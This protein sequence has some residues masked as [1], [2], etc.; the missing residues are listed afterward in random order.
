M[1]LTGKIQRRVYLILSRAVYFLAY[2]VLLAFALS[3]SEKWRNRLGW[4]FDL[5]S[6]FEGYNKE[7]KR[8]ILVWAHAAS[9]GEV[10]A[11]SILIHKYLGDSA[12]TRA[13][14]TVMTDTGH[15]TARTEFHDY[16]EREMV[17]VRYLPLDCC[18]RLEGIIKSASPNLFVF[19][20]TEIW[21]RW[22]EAL[23][24]TGVAI[25]L[26]NARISL[27][28]FPRY[29]YFRSWI[30]SLLRRYAIILAQNEGDKERFLALGVQAEKI[31]V[32][33][34]LKFSA[35][36]KTS[37]AKE[38]E[39]I[40]D[41]LGLKATDRILVAGSVRPAEESGL[42]KSYVTLKKEFPIL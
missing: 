27:K 37:N 34:N 5:S 3:G 38:R 25:A 15:A 9:V 36:V 4:G 29:F 41:S 1:T 13:L 17:V 16:I 35:H 19:I 24:K 14:I 40:L 23:D 18:G 32:T 21:P 26:V 30:G 6:L 33:G 12:D 10:R 7:S 2:P 20:E 28:S 8:A 22:I 11:L 42:I 39:K 31:H